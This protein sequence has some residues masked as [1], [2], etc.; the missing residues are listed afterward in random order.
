VIDFIPLAVAALAALLLAVLPRVRRKAPPRLRPIG[1]LT[2]LYRA[3]GLGIEDGTRFLVA[4]G[5]QSTL[6]PHA[7]SG[8]A[9]LALLR[10]VAQKASV[11]DQPPL[12]ASG[13]AAVA[14]LSQDS[15]QAGYRAVGAAEYF[16]PATG[17]LVGLTQF[18]SAAAIMTFLNDDR[19]SAAALIGHFGAEAA[20][21]ADAADR[22]GVFLL[23]A[24]SDPSAQAALFAT[25]SDTLIGEE[26]FAAP[27]YFSGRPSFVAG[28]TVQDILRW[29]VVIALLVGSALKFVGLF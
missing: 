26:L 24:S 10:E 1:G 29:M 11:S 20:L 25:A 22:S 5:G 18:S 19:V 21:L 2:R 27:A 17:R 7:A 16:Q 12:A 6:T 8:L 14:L 3:F 28:L 9:G 15:L 23:G 4:L 13:D